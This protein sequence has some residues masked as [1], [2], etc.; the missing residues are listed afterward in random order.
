MNIYAASDPLLGHH[1]HPVAQCA[2]AHDPHPRSCHPLEAQGIRE[3]V[4]ACQTPAHMASSSWRCAPDGSWS[5][6]LHQ[7][8]CTSLIDQYHASWQLAS[9]L[10]S[11]LLTPL[12]PAS[13]SV[14]SH[15]DYVTLCLTV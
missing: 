8:C 6:G 14:T 5:V 9:S 11:C 1:D 4:G 12:S 10:Q 7:A 2:V 3:A 13:G 15:P